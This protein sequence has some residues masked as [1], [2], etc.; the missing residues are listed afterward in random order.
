MENMRLIVSHCWEGVEFCSPDILLNKLTTTA[1][2]CAVYNNNNSLQCMYINNST[3][4]LNQFQSSH[5]HLLFQINHKSEACSEWQ[6]REGS[7]QMWHKTEKCKIKHHSDTQNHCINIVQWWRG[8]ESFDME[9]Q[10]VADLYFVKYLKK[11]TV[12]VKILSS[13]SH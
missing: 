10:T 13:V 11:P 9:S 1:P 7:H 12:R 2:A 5:D 8:M 3:L 4:L 6:L